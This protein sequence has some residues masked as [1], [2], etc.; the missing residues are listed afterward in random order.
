MLL[1]SSAIAGTGALAQT[2][3]TQVAL[4]DPTPAP[5][6]IIVTAQNVGKHPKGTD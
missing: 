5:G 1:A 2:T 6:E 3:P 4:T